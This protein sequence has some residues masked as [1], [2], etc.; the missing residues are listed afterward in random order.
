[1]S[2]PLIEGFVFDD[3][4]ET[5]INA[6]GLSPTQVQQMLAHKHK[7]VPNR[8]ERR[9]LFLLIGTDDGGACIAT[10]IE[11]AREVGFWRPITAR[12]SKKHESTVLSK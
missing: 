1:M 6:H 3:E 4:N 12:P 7:V 9:A 2:S 8:K 5:K 11:P 10:P